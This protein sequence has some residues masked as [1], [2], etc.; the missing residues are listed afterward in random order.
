MVITLYYGS[1]TLNRTT[2]VAQYG[3][4]TA[5]NLL[6]MMEKALGKTDPNKP[7]ETMITLAVLVG[8]V[9]ALLSASVGVYDQ[10][11]EPTSD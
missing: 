7:T 5:E 1:M 11:L 10:F 2:I 8:T 4:D 9:Q 3:K 6:S